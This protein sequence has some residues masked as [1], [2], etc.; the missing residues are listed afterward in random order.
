MTQSKDGPVSH[1]D[2]FELIPWLIT[3]RI[4]EDDQRRLEA[5]LLACP[6]CR[7]EVTEQQHLRQAIRRE[8]SNIEYAPQAS[9]QKLLARIDASEA[10][11]AAMDEHAASMAPATEPPVDRMPRRRWLAAAASL[12][13]VG[14]GTLF[15][16]S[17]STTPQ[18]GPAEYRTVTSPPA[19]PL[20]AGQ[21]RAVFAPNV[22]I[23]ELTRIV[24]ETR[25]TIVDGP[26]DSGVYTLDVQPGSGQSI[27]DLIEALR[28][29][30][31]VRFAEPVVAES[32]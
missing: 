12:L 20:H 31:R 22:T 13:A 30:P 23:E 1:E 17:W 19:Q 21:I 5:H 28:A 10:A 8:S 25:L 7:R 14:I 3:G 29:D 18:E 9:L 11:P 24:S 2:A 27:G 32:R 26:S 6:E 16:Q 4:A 15:Y